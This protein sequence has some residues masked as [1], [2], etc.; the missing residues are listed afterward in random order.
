MD[1]WCLYATLFALPAITAGCQ[2][3][4]IIA[5]SHTDKHGEASLSALLEAGLL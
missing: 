4:T 3:A 1:I 5:S 2:R